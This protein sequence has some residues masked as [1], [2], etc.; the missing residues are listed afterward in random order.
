MC[1]TVLAGAASAETSVFDRFGRLSYMVYGGDELAVRSNV[2]VSTPGWRKTAGVWQCEKPRVTRENGVTTWK[3]SFEVTEGKTVHFE[4]TAREQSGKTQVSVRL[5]A[6]ADLDLEGA[7]YSMDI[8]QPEF[9]GGKGAIGAE[10][11]MLPVQRPPQ[12]RFLGGEAAEFW[13][14]DQAGNRKLAVSLDQKR[15][16]SFE[17]K[18]D[19]KSGHIYSLRIAL[20]KG[21]LAKGD[22]AS[23]NMA[24]SLTGQPDTSPANLRIQAF[25]RRYKFQGF[26]GN[27]CFGIESP[28]TDYTLKNLR[29]GWARVEMGLINWAPENDQPGSR[30][31][32]EFLLQKRL[33]EMG[34][35]HVI[36]IWELPEQFYTDPGPKP[37]RQS[38][39]KIAPDKFDALVEAIGA[40]LAYGK[41]QYG[42]EPDLFSF[43]ESNI[44]IDVW[45]TP[46]EHRD[47]IKRMGAHFEK[48][49]LKTKMLLADATGPRGT[50][51]FALSA[52]NDSDALKYVGAVGF[53]SWG[54]GTPQDY[55]AWGDL[56]EWLNLPLLVT[57]LGVDA[58][59]HKGRTYDS[60]QYA[61][62]EVQ[63]YQELL[64]YARPQGTIQWEFTA[65]YGTVTDALVPTTRFWF[66]KHFTDLTPRNSDALQT[67]S[68]N[69]KVLFT[70]FA[71][72]ENG[73]RVYTLHVANLGAARSITIQGIPEDVR[74]L[75][76]IETSETEQFR[77]LPQIEV[78]RGVAK[79]Q[80][81]AQ[82]LVTLTTMQPPQAAA[83][84]GA[85]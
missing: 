27:Y 25:S 51:E 75:R 63:M 3:G 67:A 44:G 83:G 82:S 35:P 18:W 61:M 45:L 29:V 79:L 41:K 17:D 6:D 60:F 24:L 15:D 85:Q 52:A 21:N 68:D 54:G 53:H 50:H 22:T 77:A 12:K 69:A 84:G 73:A 34:I 16:I 13:V 48:L 30:L 2:A 40:Y 49:G 14:A 81:P 55:K 38:K 8:P 56:A 31:H 19:A 76:A 46:E 72:D 62:Q 10:S 28:V 5:T 39:R 71:G 36:S 43:N 20:H 58:S 4:E 11:V 66:V 47:A 1:L 80:M 26:G 9:A 64:L 65:D 37:K 70:A 32:D 23:L 74:L 57:E 42:A 78:D 33:K 7:F 59:A